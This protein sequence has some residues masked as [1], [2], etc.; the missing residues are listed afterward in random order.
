[1]STWKS[2]Q[3]ISFFILL[4]LASQP[5][6]AEP[7]S[8]PALNVQIVQPQ[9]RELM[10]NQVANGSIAAWQEAVIG[11]EIAELRLSEVRVQVGDSVH[12]DQVLAVFNADSVQADIANSRA[13]LAE[14]EANLAEALLNAERAEKIADSGALSQVQIDRYLTTEKTAKAKVQSAKA[15][16]DAQLLRLKYT[17]VKASDDGIISSRTATL[18][19]VASKGQELFKLIRQNRLEWRAEVT[20][21]EIVKLKS[22]MSVQVQV[23][24][25]GSFKGKIRTI[26]PSLDSQNRSGI[27]Y[28]DI[29]KAVEQ[30][31]RAGMFA[32]G[33]FQLAASNALTVPQEAVS[34][35]EGFSYVFMLTE[36]NA[37]IAKV[38]QIKVELGRRADNQLEI[39]NGV[40]ASDKLVA[41]GVTFLS[42]GDNVRLVQP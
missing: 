6:K 26:A 5:L 3:N 25:V 13:Q 34:L 9:Y 32:K 18:G 21:S 17:Q 19:A 12:K 31:L 29:T 20:A 38:K 1:M 14:A 10:V 40:Q 22:G 41:S 8:K 2:S 28:V 23:A 39:L 24:G 42:D 36:Q 30:G 7:T 11:A 33:E 37:D 16:L 4:L 27:V 35:R 15:Q